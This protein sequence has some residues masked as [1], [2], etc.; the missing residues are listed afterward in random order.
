MQ[1][2]H[3]QMQNERLLQ[4]LAALRQTVISREGSQNEPPAGAAGFQYPRGAALWVS[5][6]EA[7]DMA[8][9]LIYLRELLHVIRG[10]PELQHAMGSEGVLFLQMDD[11]QASKRQRTGG[12]LS[13][14]SQPT[15]MLRL[16][17]I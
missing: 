5:E 12:P 11:Q 2:Q 7:L 6:F 15:P 8:H 9:R 13:S 3:T 14:F 4:E 16:S 1:V 17:S 10:S